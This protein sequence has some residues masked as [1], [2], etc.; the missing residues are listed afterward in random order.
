MTT[1][2]DHR[3]CGDVVRLIK[4]VSLVA[5]GCG[6][7]EH[8]VGVPAFRVFQFR[9]AALQVILR[10]SKA[11]N[12]RQLVIERIQKGSAVRTGDH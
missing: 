7:C 6:L 12:G 5:R 10:V 9:H 2:V 8:H 1:R 4:I 3:Y 11:A